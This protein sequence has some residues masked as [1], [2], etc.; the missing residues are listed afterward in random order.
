MYATPVN[1]AAIIAAVRTPI[2]RY[3]GSRASVGPTIWPHKRY[4]LW[5]IDQVSTL[6]IDDV[7]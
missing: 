1:R 3:G 7:Y 2:G 4:V 6:S 5:L